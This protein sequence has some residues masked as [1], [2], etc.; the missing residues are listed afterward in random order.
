MAGA[1]DAWYQAREKANSDLLIE[2]IGGAL[3]GCLGGMLPDIFEP[4]DSSW[5]RDVAHSA[6]VG[7]GVLAL[8]A[9]LAE[10]AQEC[11]DKAQQY[12]AI[13]MVVVPGLSTFV[14]APADPLKQL[15]GNLA[16][17]FWGLLAGF[18]NG[19]SAGYASHLLLDA[20]TP[21]GIP[22]LAGRF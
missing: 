13:Q 22:L 1:F 11:R 12:R 2:T 8:R 14:P 16:E 7:G 10:M 15:L 20:A 6:T 3:G 19:L 4:A 21:R 5:H 17:L 18:L 9:T